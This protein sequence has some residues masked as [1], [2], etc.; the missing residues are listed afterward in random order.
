MADPLLHRCGCKRHPSGSISTMIWGVVAALCP[1]HGDPVANK[2]CGCCN[3]CGTVSGENHDDP[4]WWPCVPCG[5]T[6]L[7]AKRQYAEP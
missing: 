2:P 6:G 4:K 7:R 5:G 1:V 3:G